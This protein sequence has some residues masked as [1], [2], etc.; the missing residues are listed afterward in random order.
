[1][2]EFT[3]IGNE[4]IYLRFV[5]KENGL[6]LNSISTSGEDPVRYDG[7]LPFVFCPV[8]AS[9]G[10]NGGDVSAY[11]NGLGNFQ[12]RSF[13]RLGD[14]LFVAYASEEYGAR[15]ECRFTFIENSGA[16]RVN[17]TVYAEREFAFTDFYSILP[18]CHFE[19]T[20]SDNYALSYRKNKWQGEGQWK[21]ESLTALDF[22]DYYRHSPLNYFSVENYGSQTTS[23]YYPSLLLSQQE[24]GERWLLEGIPQG[25]WSAALTQWR[26]HCQTR[27]VLLFSFA[28][29]EERKLHSTVRLRAG[30]S[31]RAASLVL[32]AGNRA[33]S[34]F[35]ALYAEKRTGT[36]CVKKPTLLFNDYMNCLWAKPSWE[37]EKPLIDACEKLGAEYFIVDDGWFCYREE[38]G[39]RLG[40]WN[41]DGDALGGGGLRG[42][43]D[44]IQ[45]KGMKAG[46]WLE[47]EVVGD[48]SLPYRRYREWLLTVDGKPYGTPARYFLDFRKKEVK[49]YLTEKVRSLYDMGAR[50][51]KLDYNDSYFRADGGASLT[52]LQENYVEVKNFYRSLR[53]EFPDALFENCAS[54]AKRSDGGILSEFDLQ[55]VSDQEEYWRY[56]SLLAGSLVNNPPER[57][58]VWCMPYAVRFYRQNEADTP[59]PER[60][61]I[62]FNLVNALT[63]VFTLS[64]RIDLLNERDL[65]LVAEGVKTYRE[66]F[67][68]LLKSY[69]AYPLGFTGV[70]SKRHALSFVNE[71]KELLYLWATG[72][73]EFVIPE[74]EKYAQ[75]FP[76]EIDCK[77]TKNTVTLPTTRSARI[78]YKER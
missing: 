9:N 5:R 77:I 76:K 74:A 41:T 24:S 64:S 13:Q 69:P 32:C 45:A 48:N 34:V 33:E 11:K 15:V 66:I 17:A 47:P 53:E 26:G 44:Y 22:T 70:R 51:F 1:M 61:E 23:E 12:M 21:T 3:I 59:Y 52:A 72:E 65:R 4:K 56:P 39:R 50:Y 19:P 16:V 73:N 68:L 78:F 60:E 38:V 30:E 2:S 43:F 35:K 7:F 58:G 27:G 37:K 10:T 57:T 31:F 67:P 28:C 63:G 14:T 55:S 71:E 40:D 6:L 25:S 42:L 8:G 36:H 29:T 49:A 54:G 46:I 75:I 62:I 20:E 18:L